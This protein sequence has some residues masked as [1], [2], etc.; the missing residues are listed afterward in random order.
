[1]SLCLVFAQALSACACAVESCASSA[2]SALSSASLL[3]RASRVTAPDPEATPAGMPPDGGG[4]VGVSRGGG[5][6]GAGGGT[7]IC[8]RASFVAVAAP[9]LVEPV[10]ASKGREPGRFVLL[11]GGFWVVTGGR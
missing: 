5:G 10:F 8:G 11:V 7:A 3:S 9:V 4:A 1:M 2:L 6:G